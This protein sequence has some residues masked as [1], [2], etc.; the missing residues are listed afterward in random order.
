MSA[1]KYEPLR[2]YLA[3]NR[4]GPIC[5]TFS[6]IEELIRERLPASARRHRTWWSNNPLNSAIA[7]AWLDAGFKSSAVNMDSKKLVFLKT[8]KAD[9]SPACASTSP[10]AARSLPKGDHPIFGCLKG[11]VKVAEGVDLTEPADPH[12]AERAE[13]QALIDG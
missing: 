7:R 12:W 9:E 4:D 1:S 10:L 13:T 6:E 2:E 5:M 11:T 3:D 8:P